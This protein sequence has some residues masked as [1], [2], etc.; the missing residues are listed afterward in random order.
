[1]SIHPI[2][3]EVYQWFFDLPPGQH[4]GQPTRKYGFLV[5]IG[6]TNRGLRDVSINYWHLF[7][8]IRNKTSIELKPLTITE[9][10]VTIGQIAEKVYP[11]LGAKGVLFT[12]DTMI[13]S[14][15]SIAGF[16]CYMAEFYGH[17]N[18]N[19]LIENGKA[20]GKMVVKSVFNN[21]A[22]VKIEFSR[23]ELAR[24]QQMIPHIETVDQQ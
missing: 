15:D 20:I 17:E 7:L 3:P 6:I 10:K 8:K 16:A 24:A 1:M 22:I 13:R 18:F 19:P 21:K 5:Y 4:E 11:V 9:P 2:H 14:G 12:G 23:I